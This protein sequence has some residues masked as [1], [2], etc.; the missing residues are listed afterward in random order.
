MSK[1]DFCGKEVVLPFECKF[2]GDKFCIEHRLPENHSCP[3]APPRT[4][5]GHW[6]AKIRRLEPKEFP[7]LPRRT[8]A[9]ETLC[10]PRCASERVQITAYRPDYAYYL[11][12]D[13]G[14]KWEEK[15]GETKPRIGRREIKNLLS[16]YLVGAIVAIVGLAIVFWQ[17]YSPLLMFLLFFYVIPIPLIL[18]GTILFSLGFLVIVG[19]IVSMIRTPSISI[20]LVA[21]PCLIGLLIFSSFEKW[22]IF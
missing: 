22:M 19:T 17:V 16:S 7:S 18:I 1:C 2:C 12:L 11:C 4:P 8:R 15:K 20:K 5:L 14:C 3:Q 13:C 10:C 9:E 6:K 21:I